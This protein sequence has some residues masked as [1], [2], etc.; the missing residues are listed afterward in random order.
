MRS[1]SYYK[2]RRL[3]RVVFWISVLVIFYLISTKL[4]WDGAGYCVGSL[5]MCE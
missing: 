4:W 5:E 3:V 2:V 1:N